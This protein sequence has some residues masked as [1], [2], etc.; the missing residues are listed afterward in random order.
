MKKETKPKVESSEYAVVEA[1]GKQYIVKA[2]QILKI[3]KLEDDSKVGDKLKLDKVLLID[4]GKETKIGAP[5]L[6]GK[7]IETEVVEAAKDKKITVIKYKAKS[8]YFVK[9][10]HRQ[11]FLK[12]KVLEIK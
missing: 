2:G 4:D 12:V 1:G 5:Y 10:G 3:A 9:R 8:N 6:K 11:H 7:S